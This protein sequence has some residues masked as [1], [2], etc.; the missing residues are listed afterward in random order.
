MWALFIALSPLAYVASG[1][2]VS[3]NNPAVHFKFP[4]DRADAVRE[5]TRYASS[6]GYDTGRWTNGVRVEANNDRYYYYLMHAGAEADRLSRVIPSARVHVIFLSPDK[7]EIL[8]VFLRPD[9][10]VLGYDYEPSPT[11][12]IADPGE[13]ESKRVAS[14]AYEA[15]RREAGLT[16]SVE[17]TPSEERKFNRVTRR[18][19]WQLP[20]DS[21]PHLK[22]NI[23]VA[24]VGGQ[25][26]EQSLS[27]EI[28]SKYTQ[29]RF[30]NRNIWPRVATVIY[31]I[32]L[33]V[34]C[35]YGLYRYVRRTLQKEVPHARSLLLGGVASVTLFF[36]SL[37]SQ[38]HIFSMTAATGGGALQYWVQFIAFGIFFGLYGMTMGLAY[39]GGEGDVREAYPGK[40]ASLDALLTG[41][42]ASRNVARALLIG[43]AAGGWAALVSALV[44]LP[45][46]QHPA[47]GLGLPD[48]FYTLFYGNAP[49]M[50]PLTG[51]PLTAIQAATLGLL[52]P[53]S[54]LLRVKRL[55]SE[56]LMLVLIAALSF[57]AALGIFQ[58]QPTP[59]VAGLLM[60][61][62][63]TA[64]LLFLFFTFDLLTAMVGSLAPSLFLNALYYIAQP[65]ASIQRAGYFAAGIGLVSLAGAVFYLL[66]G[67]E[68]SED[69]VR[70][71]Y[72][73]YLA[74]R[75]RLEAEVSAAREAQ[76]RLLPQT[77]PEVPGLSLAAACHPSRV[78]GGDFYDLFTLGERRL[79][80]FVAEGSNHG[81]GAALTIAFAKGFLMP[82]IAADHTPAE[83][84]CSLQERLAP[85]LEE[86]QE[87][88]LVYAV[89]DAPTRTLTY[90][91][92]GHYPQVRISRAEE[93]DDNG[94]AA[95]AKKRGRRREVEPTEEEVKPS[96]VNPA[97]QNCLIRA[98]QVQLAPGDAVFF[99]TD[100]VVESFTAERKA[101]VETWAA[102]VV[103]G[104]R[105]GALQQS[106]DKA[107]EKSARRIKKT[108]V[109]DDLTAVVVYLN[110]NGS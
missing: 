65:P 55:R 45:W 80:I 21:L 12:E 34:V 32:F 18:Y 59:F 37:Q 7:R 48:N 95:R 44:I 36:I 15:L 25:I 19:R 96:S 91:R 29:S 9:G 60:A 52:L 73:R 72:A 24:V 38:F 87:M 82:R 74:E 31:V 107:L 69:E 89:F 76:V 62:V 58:E 71:L 11:A 33:L 97:A 20:H 1:V 70:P 68:Y 49:W 39:G 57:M 98:A 23:A 5:A 103:G 66:R 13:E 4:L 53:L 3:Q 84:V 109:E 101:S 83:I 26:T 94:R 92:A 43:T 105:K 30:V 2:F 54:F 99:V 85:M 17:P 47:T 63:R 41:R 75:Q 104:R 61:A 81:L 100:A 88:A 93:A 22:V 46:T 56:R 35:I 40:M 86:N 27:T 106:L 42:F 51:P 67:R 8:E 10:H 110:S 90:A 64:L 16:N 77:L 102:E 78:V 50:L 14:E 108:G 28:D 79:S 6:L